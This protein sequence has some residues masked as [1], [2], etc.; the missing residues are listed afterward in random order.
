MIYISLWFVVKENKKFLSV[1]VFFLLGIYYLLFEDLKRF[2][3]LIF[4]K[5]LKSFNLFEML[6]NDFIM[7][8]KDLFGVSNLIK[9]FDIRIN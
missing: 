7:Y 1:W 6:F 5:V 2:L 4:I 9:M 8:E 3:V